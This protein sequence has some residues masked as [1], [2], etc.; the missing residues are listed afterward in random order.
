MLPQAGA[1]PRRMVARA[2]RQ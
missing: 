1:Q 2:E